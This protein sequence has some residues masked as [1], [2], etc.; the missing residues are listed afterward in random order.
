MRVDAASKAKMENVDVLI[1]G[2]GPVGAT[3]ARTL[4]DAGRKVLMIDVGE[5]VTRLVGDHR[6]NSVAVQKDISL[7][8][9]SVKG[10]L[11]P[12]SVPTNT[13]EPYVE[14][15]SWSPTP[16]QLSYLQNGQN[17]HQKSY[18]NLPAAAATRHP[19]IERSTLFNNEEWDELYTKSEELLKTNSVSFDKSIRQQLVKH[20][21]A[22]AFEGRKMLSMPLACKRSEQ[23]KE[24]VQWSCAA[25]ILG[26]LAEPRYSGDAF[27]IRPNTQCL[28]LQLDSADNQVAWALVKDLMADK[29]YYIKAKKYVVCAGA[30]LTPGI[31]FNSGL[32]EHLPALGHYMNEQSMAF[33]Q[34]IL[35]KS[36]VDNVK[37]DPYGLGWKQIVEEHEAKAPKDPLPFPF[38]DPDPQ[39]YFPLSDAHHWHTQI[40]RDSFGY[41]EVPATIDQRLV[42]DFR[43]FTYVKPV[44]TNYVEFSKEYQDE[45][46][47]PQPTFHFTL[48][49]E[50]SDRSLDMLTDMVN[51]ARKLGG[52][53]PGA[54]PKYLAPGSALH[55]C[56]TYRAGKSK[57]DSV[58]DRYVKVWEQN[59]LVLGGCG[60]IPTQNA[61]NPTITAIAFALAAARQMGWSMKCSKDQKPG[62]CAMLFAWR[63]G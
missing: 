17:P 36:L 26:D 63:I 15:A 10:E 25:T 32:K 47:M 9:N 49:E 13:V 16:D 55:I 37:N 4:V 40:H 38:E 58:V 52:F 22:D 21:L 50:D 24:Y 48:S 56:G 8:T 1:V 54:E 19:K 57:K 43:W 51:V 29:K 2:S 59:D 41:G 6:K 46:G 44:Y 62:S 42:V 7:F 45:F 14:P 12:L 3:F 18:G 61:S 31:L 11:H 35:K 53:L 60:V 5:Q 23:N 30:I 33:C 39:C 20:V 34:V 27:E 28:Q